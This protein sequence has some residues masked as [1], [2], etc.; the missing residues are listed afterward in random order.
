MLEKKKVEKK[1]VGKRELDKKELDKKKLKK[2]ELE[3]S[4]IN[5]EL[6]NKVNL[7]KRKKLFLKIFN[8]AKKTYG[9]NT[10]RLAGEGWEKDWQLLFA[11]MMSAQTKDETTIPVS[12]DLF[13]KYSSLNKIANEK[14]E[15]IL[16]IIRRVNY[17]RTKAKNLKM[18]A[19][20]ILDNYSGIVPETIDDLILIPG[21]G[22][23][24]ANLVLGELHDAKAICVDTHVHRISNV[25]G[26]V[27][28][29]T[30]KETELELQKVAPTKYWNKI[31]RLFVLWG[32]ETSGNDS[33][34]L[35]KKIG[36]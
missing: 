28:T 35:L 27:K 31:N 15:N 2:S 19:K 12:I 17:N 24:T 7:D 33:E 3:K 11:T 4:R 32:K 26:I 29:K 25:L 34:K 30:P 16:L 5:K 6:Q 22:R 10:K 9:K 23:K 13:K 20:F 21:V 1:E 8:A 14:E 36:L 18:A